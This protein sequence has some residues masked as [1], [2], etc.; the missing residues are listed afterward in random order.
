[1]QRWA[2]D[3]TNTNTTLFSVDRS[4]GRC[5][6][7]Q[8]TRRETRVL[9][10]AGERT[11]CQGNNTSWYCGNCRPPCWPAACWCPASLTGPHQ[12]ILPPARLCTSSCFREQCSVKSWSC[13]TGKDGVAL[14]CP[15]D[16][17]PLLLSDF[18]VLELK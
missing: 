9:L 5:T 12:D 8:K 2:H 18:K 16:F 11:W 3:H 6:S 15:G 13:D 1:M 10:V 14:K 4:S 17:R 7:K